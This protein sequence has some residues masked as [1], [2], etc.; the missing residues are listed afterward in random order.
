MKINKVL[1]FDIGGTKIA[2]ATVDRNGKILNEVI[3]HPTPA[4][5]GAAA[6][7]LK[8]II[9]QF[10]DQIDAVAVSTAGTVDRTN[11]RIT[12]S[13]GNMPEGYMDT[14]FKALSA[15]PVVVEN[16]AN[17]AVWAEHV[18]GNAKGHDNVILLTLG[19]GVGVG[20][21]ADGRLLVGK[22]GAAGEVHFPVRYDNNRL[23]GCGRYDCL[24]IYMSGKALSL[25]AKAAYKDDNATSHTVIEGLKQ[26][27]LPAVT[28]FHNWQEMVKNG[29]VIFADI[30]DPEVILLGGSMAHFIDYK[31]LN[32]E[33]NRMIVTTPFKLKEA[34]FENDAG[35]IGA[36]LLCV[37]KL[38]KKAV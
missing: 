31:R 32:D 23:C 11:S 12:G 5:P 6:K 3:R 2:Y 17:S 16:D 36:A 25:E 20:I 30:F 19:T 8:T 9:A 24:E 26:N 34:S 10:E 38:E 21:I 18:L 13:V 33:A 27:A 7:L 29:I 37:Q 4:A 22:S 35:L 14:D 1:A 28:A 15:K